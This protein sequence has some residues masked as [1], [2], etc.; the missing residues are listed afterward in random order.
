MQFQKWGLN[1]LQKKWMK[2]NRQTAVTISRR[3]ESGIP[4]PLPGIL[5]SMSIAMRGANF[6]WFCITNHLNAILIGVVKQEVNKSAGNSGFIGN[7]C[8]AEQAASWMQFRLDM[9]GDRS[10]DEPWAATCS[11]YSRSCCSANC[12]KL[13]TIIPAFEQS[14]TNIEGD[15]IL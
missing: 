9:G 6:P 1:F 2:K 5:S 10:A 14:Y 4:T 11:W 12:S 13:E 3:F 15:P 8:V 7:S